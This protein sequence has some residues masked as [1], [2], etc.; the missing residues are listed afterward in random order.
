M[1]LELRKSVTALKNDLEHGAGWNTRQSLQIL[2]TACLESMA[3]SKAKLEAEIAEVAGALIQARPYMVSLANY[4]YKF[5]QELSRQASGLKTA[6]AV[7]RRGV[8]L[9]EKLARQAAKSSSL[10]SR[11][12]V[13]LIGRRNI[14]MT[15]SYSSAA[16]TALELARKK[17]TEFKVL[18]VESRQ[19][20][21]SYGKM[22]AERLEK[23]GIECRLVP[24]SQIDWHTARANIILIGADTV[25]LHGWLMNGT[26]SLEAAR[27]AKRKKVPVYSVCETAKFDVNGF[28][29]VIRRPEP[30]FDMVP[31]E[32]LTGLVTE[33]GIMQPD[34]VFDMTSEDILWSL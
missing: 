22:T 6:G 12:A 21:K 9:A 13:K 5:R 25:S 3:P 26:P 32:L 8:A 20:R 7:K 15:V 33:R 27:S 18:A 29:A 17:G 11:N 2:K 19:G 23:A 28:T 24:D 30:G 16:C 31:L 10:A 1:K 4:S 34:A 14:V